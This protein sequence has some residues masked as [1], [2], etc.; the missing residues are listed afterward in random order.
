MC[1]VVSLLV[2][3]WV[4]QGAE[5]DV[6]ALLSPKGLLPCPRHV[7]GRAGSVLRAAFW[8]GFRVDLGWIWGP[9]AY[10]HTHTEPGGRQVAVSARQRGR[11]PARQPLP[12]V[13]KL[14]LLNCTI[15]YRNFLIG[16]GQL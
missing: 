12:R 3:F 11:A 9:P 16:R 14:L 4:K 13:F 8:G 15:S 7:W 5:R 1:V 6:A 10:T 2:P